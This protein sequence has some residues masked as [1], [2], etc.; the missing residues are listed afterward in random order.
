MNAI[1]DNRSRAFSKR[2]TLILPRFH[3][4]CNLDYTGVIGIKLCHVLLKDIFFLISKRIRHSG[5]PDGLE[6]L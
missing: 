2:T 6:N 3:S 4:Y 5:K 1:H